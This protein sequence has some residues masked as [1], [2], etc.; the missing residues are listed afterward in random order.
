MVNSASKIEFCSK[1][2]SPPTGRRLK[3][4]SRPKICPK[5]EVGPKRLVGGEISPCP[6]AGQWWERAL[7][8]GLAALTKRVP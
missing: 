7:E 2:V 1:T 8:N 5:P 3:T 6:L 4:R